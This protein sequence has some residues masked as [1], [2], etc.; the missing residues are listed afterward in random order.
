MCTS[1]YYPWEFMLI[2]RNFLKTVW[3]HMGSDICYGFGKKTS[4]IVKT[5]RFD[6]SDL[7]EYC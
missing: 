4:L 1:F 3:F 6:T 5:I 7:L 2:L